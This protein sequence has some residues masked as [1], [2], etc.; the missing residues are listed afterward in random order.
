MT[1]FRQ[2]GTEAAVGDVTVKVDGTPLALTVL[3]QG[4]SG[5]PGAV[6]APCG[7]YTR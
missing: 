5:G 6:W 1:P 3:P 2:Q 4:I 7:V